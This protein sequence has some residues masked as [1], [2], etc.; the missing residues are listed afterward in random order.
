LPEPELRCLLLRKNGVPYWAKPSK[1]GAG[2]E[3]C[4]WKDNCRL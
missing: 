1:S 4:S 2:Q 3:K